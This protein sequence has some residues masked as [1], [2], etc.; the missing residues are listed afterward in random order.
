M[1][2]LENVG[3]TFPKWPNG[4]MTICASHVPRGHN[5]AYTVFIP[6][7]FLVCNQE[8]MT[9]NKPL[10]VGGIIDINYKLYQ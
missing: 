2:V 8:S 6:T 7:I 10:G 3:N 4:D 9:I 1:N 5:Y